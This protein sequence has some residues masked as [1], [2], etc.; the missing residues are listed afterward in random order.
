MNNYYDRNS[1]PISFEEWGKLFSNKEYQILQQNRLQNG[2]YISTVWLG[3]AHG[4][5]GSG[6]L[7]FETLVTHPD[8]KEE[9]MYRYST[10]KQA[11][12]HH[13]FLCKEE[14]TYIG[15]ENA[16]RWDHIQWELNDED[17]QE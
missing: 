14:T 8:N 5:D 17:N 1:D 7:I 12:E 2:S 4:Y 9:E 15:K 10:E 6:P 13:K 3:L 11:L 16:S